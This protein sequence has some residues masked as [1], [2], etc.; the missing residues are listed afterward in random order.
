MGV[1]FCLSSTLDGSVILDI[2][3]QPNS[4]KQGLMGFN[5]WRSRL[6]VAVRAEPKD[7]QAN[8]AVVHVLATVLRLDAAALIITSG[9]RSRFK[10]V[11]IDGISLDEMI[12]RIDEG[13][14]GLP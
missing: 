7:G 6:R 4:T 8:R 5:R 12:R 1:G 11:R 9:H 3:V 14:E 10:S 13:L 2:E